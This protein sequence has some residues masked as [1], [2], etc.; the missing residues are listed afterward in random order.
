[1]LRAFAVWWVNC[2]DWHSWTG[3]GVRSGQ[4]VDKLCSRGL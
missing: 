1:M 2:T 3:G 4:P